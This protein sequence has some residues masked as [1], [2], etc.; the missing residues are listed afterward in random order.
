MVLETKAP[1]RYFVESV[2]NSWESQ[3]LASILGIIGSTP[4]SSMG[5]LV[6]MYGNETPLEYQDILEHLAPSYLW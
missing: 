2:S 6:N 5:V 3:A 1:A 4:L